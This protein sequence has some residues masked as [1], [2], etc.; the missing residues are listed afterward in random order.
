MRGIYVW[1]SEGACIVSAPQELL[2]DVAGPIGGADPE[3]VIDGRSLR[4]ILGGRLGRTIGPAVISYAD[5]G[6]FIRQEEQGA[7]PLIPSDDDA[8]K[9]LSREVG[10]E[11][12]VNSN[13]SFERVPIFGIYEQRR[14]VAAASY[15]R[16]GERIL[17]IGVVT[18]PDYRGQGFGRGVAAATTAHALEAGG[19][20]QW[21]T[22]ES[23]AASARIADALGFKSH[24]RTLFL[25]LK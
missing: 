20:A 10:E 15:E 3:Q 12:W 17:H 1:E 19:I 22:L 9:E 2:M 14:M 6:D 11:A 8:L 18:H 24:C 4:D 23:N 13:I 25:Q 7:R 5:G 21:Q 16:W